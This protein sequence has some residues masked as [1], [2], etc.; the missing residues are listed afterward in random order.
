MKKGFY[1]DGDLIMPILFAFFMLFFFA[2]LCLSKENPMIALALLIIFAIL[3]V[4]VLVP[5]V[6]GNDEA[7]PKQYT[8]EELASAHKER[9]KQLREDAKFRFSKWGYTYKSVNRVEKR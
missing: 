3:V 9:M 5:F 2:L 8:K 1:G 4:C 7:K 6:G